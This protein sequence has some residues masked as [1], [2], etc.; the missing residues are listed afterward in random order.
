MR[1]I[2]LCVDI[3]GLLRKSDRELKGWIKDDS[4]RIVTPSEARELLLDEI[5]KGRKVLPGSYPPCEGFSYETGC[6]GHVQET[7]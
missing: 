7:V 6:P 2:H 1:T 3:R 4:G 5:A